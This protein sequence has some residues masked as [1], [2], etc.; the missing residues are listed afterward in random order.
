MIFLDTN[1]WIN[2]LVITSSN[3]E[4]ENIQIQKAS[5][6]LKSNTEKII[7]C[8]EQL[9]ELIN[10]ILKIKRREYNRTLKESGLK[11]ITG[12]GSLKE[13][14]QRKEF[15]DAIALCKMI[16]SDISHFA[17]VEDKF[18]YNIEDIINHLSY[19]DINDYI[20]LRYCQNKGIRLYTF[21]KELAN[22]DN[23]NVVVL[24]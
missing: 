17:D 23:K 14:R 8:R 10:A 12:V 20:Y 1:I 19:S 16:Y 21:D 9:I 24:L 18:S 22:S 15:S 7:T 11:N 6:F 13:F 4:Y 5:S 3:K 2:A